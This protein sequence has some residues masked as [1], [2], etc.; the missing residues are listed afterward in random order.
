M[1]ARQR[2]A[3]VGLDQQQNQLGHEHLEEQN[4]EAE[5]ELRN[6][7]GALKSLTIDIGSTIR[8]HNK[9]LKEVDDEFDSTFGQLLHNITRVVKLAK[10]GSRWHFFYL[11]LFC[12]FVFL[13][14]WWLIK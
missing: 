5:L 12:L 8:E 7:V 1:N 2:G 6:K 3:H 9:Y 14:L 4:E 10:S 13:V 11:F